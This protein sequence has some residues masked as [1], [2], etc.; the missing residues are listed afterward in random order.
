MSDLTADPQALRQRLLDST[1]GA[2]KDVINDA[3]RNDGYNAPPED[4]LTPGM[5]H[6][7][8]GFGLPAISF[9]IASDGQTVD[10]VILLD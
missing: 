2:W 1:G 3:T 9:T 7:L 5:A 8:T 4:M 10:D 6:R